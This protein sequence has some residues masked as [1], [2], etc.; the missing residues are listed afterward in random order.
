MLECGELEVK[1]ITAIAQAA[2]FKRWRGALQWRLQ[3]EAVDLN[4]QNASAGT[5]GPA[6]N[7]VVFAPGARAKRWLQPGERLGKGGVRNKR[8]RRVQP[9]A[10]MRRHDGKEPVGQGVG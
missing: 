8:G 3:H 7:D 9:V 1:T 4:L 5:H 2:G 10:K 6:G